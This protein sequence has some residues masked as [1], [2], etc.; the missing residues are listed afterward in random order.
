MQYR[1]RNGFG[2]MNTGTATGTYRN[3]N[4]RQYTVLD[5]E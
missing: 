2:G 5:V 1:A 4:C 3:S